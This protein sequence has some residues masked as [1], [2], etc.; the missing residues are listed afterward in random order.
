MCINR[1]VLTIAI[2]RLQNKFEGS[3]I[4]M[5]AKTLFIKIR[6]GAAYWDRL[7]H[8]RLDRL[9]CPKSHEAWDFHMGGQ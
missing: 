3:R 8:S 6:L 4:V 7:K 5:L 1:T 2:H 9:D